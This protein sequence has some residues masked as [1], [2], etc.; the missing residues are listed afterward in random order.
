MPRPLLLRIPGHF[1]LDS[2]FWF[3]ILWESSAVL[4]V[5]HHDWIQYDPRSRQ[6]YWELIQPQVNTIMGFLIH[7]RI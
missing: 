5:F 2:W 3:V 6:V 1:Y 7:W 4:L